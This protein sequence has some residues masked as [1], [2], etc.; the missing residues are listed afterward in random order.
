VP[1]FENLNLR[2]VNAR[3]QIENRDM[4]EKRA[5]IER[6]QARLM[7]CLKLR[8]QT[9]WAAMH[10]GWVVESA[11]Q[12]RESRPLTVREA[13]DSAIKTVSEGLT[14]EQLAWLERVRKE[15]DSFPGVSAARDQLVLVESS[16]EKPAS[17]A[18]ILEAGENLRHVSSYGSA[19]LSECQ[20]ALD[21]K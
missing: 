14:S 12:Q 6:H 19:I 1:Y 17:E 2:E 7:A 5:S 9:G 16:K 8:T 11:L 15:V 20:R 18:D 21:E 3:L 4:L 13:I 10:L